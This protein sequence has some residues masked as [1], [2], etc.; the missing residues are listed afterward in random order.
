MVLVSFLQFITAYK[1]VQLKYISDSMCKTQL[2]LV[3][4]ARFADTQITIQFVHAI[5]EF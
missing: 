5:G 4:L 3:H 1:G 2:Y